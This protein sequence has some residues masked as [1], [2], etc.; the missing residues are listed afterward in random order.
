MKNQELKL[1]EWIDNAVRGKEGYEMVCPKDK[2][3]V[4]KLEEF[5]QNVSC[6]LVVV[7]KEGELIFKYVWK[8]E[9]G[10]EPINLGFVIK[11]HKK[12]LL[13]TDSGHIYSCGFEQTDVD[14]MIFYNVDIENTIIAASG[15]SGKMD[16]QT[17][18]KP[19]EN[20]AMCAVM[21]RLSEEIGNVV[22]ALQEGET[23]TND[24]SE[25]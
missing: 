19:L 23:D 10:D 9:N 14:I 7:W 1:K 17:Y 6:L 22:V 25:K 20:E 8:S 12:M 5:A 15:K 4:C 21:F 2:N 3:F 24:R 16:M 11:R 18:I 13:C